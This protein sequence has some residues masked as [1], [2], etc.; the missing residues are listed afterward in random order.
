MGWFRNYQFWDSLQFF[1]PFNSRFLDV[2]G[3]K[4]CENSAMLAMIPTWL[5][6]ILVW[7]PPL[8]VPFTPIPTTHSF[9][10]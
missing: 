5:N 8:I 6:P 7:L 9:I 10:T 2:D 3:Q 4:L 1:V